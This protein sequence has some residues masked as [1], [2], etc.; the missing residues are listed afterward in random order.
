MSRFDFPTDK[1]GL[2]VSVRDATEARA[3]LAG[4]AD[5]I[6]VKE[7]NRGSL[8]AA[9]SGTISEIVRVVDG[10]ATVS[11]AMGELAEQ[12]QPENGANYHSVPKGVS[13]FK[14]GLANCAGIRGWQLGWQQTTAAIV[15][16]ASTEI[17]RPVAVI[18]ADWRAA[19]APPPPDVLS[20]AV[21]HQCPAL[22][23]DTWDKSAG[24]LFEHW[25]VADLRLFLADV[26][27]RSIAVVL[28]GSLTDKNIARAAQ[29]GP[30]L[31]AV[32]T[33]ACDGGRMG[34]VSENKVRDLKAAIRTATKDMAIY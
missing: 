12:N 18:Y 17:L 34:V 9:D 21:S 2:L 3:A 10:R 1:P 8:G 26:R 32:R 4:G 13:L 14:L 20:L 19:Q 15:A 25:S 24:T 29:L 22:L 23:I 16:A 30:D 11:I 28:A 33:A 6:D 7:P 5:V 27:E 31:V